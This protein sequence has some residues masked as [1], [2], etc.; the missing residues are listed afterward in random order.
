M[1][2]NCRDTPK[3]YGGDIS[4]MHYV[5]VRNISDGIA[6]VEDCFSTSL[7]QEQVM[8]QKISLIEWERIRINIFF[9][10]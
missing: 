3:F 9:K 8:S 7:V 10:T 4:E 5:F 2:R 1:W 6:V